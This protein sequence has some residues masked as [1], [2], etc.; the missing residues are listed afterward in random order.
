MPSDDGDP[1]GHDEVRRAGFGTPE[2]LSEA[3]VL[4]R[5]YAELQKEY[6]A[7]WQSHCCNST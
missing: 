2:D 7:F 3:A 4:K 6:E 5:S 1:Q